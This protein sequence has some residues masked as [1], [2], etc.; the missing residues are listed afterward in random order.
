LKERLSFDI[1]L[2]DCIEVSRIEIS[3]LALSVVKPGGLILVDNYDAE[4]CQGISQV[5]FGQTKAQIAYD[6]PHWAGRGTM[7]YYM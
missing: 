6:D 5:F 2:V 3:K 4:Y 7:V 1:V